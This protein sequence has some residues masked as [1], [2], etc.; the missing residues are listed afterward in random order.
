MLDLQSKISRFLIF[1]IMSE[2]KSLMWRI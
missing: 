1:K 2:K